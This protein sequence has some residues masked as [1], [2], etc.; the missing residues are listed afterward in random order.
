MH[1]S[2]S[3]D[4]VVSVDIVPQHKKKKMQHDDSSR[5]FSDESSYVNDT[6]YPGTNRPTF[7]Q[8]QEL[9]TPSQQTV[10]RLW[11]MKV[12]MSNHINQFTGDINMLI[13]IPI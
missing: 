1:A 12:N 5:V 10:A 13:L 9:I 3:S 11:K 6:P 2:S 8:V 4:T 7:A